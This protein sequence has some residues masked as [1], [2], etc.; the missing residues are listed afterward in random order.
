M[1]IPEIFFVCFVNSIG[2]KC[3]ETVFLLAY[4][5]ISFA[6]KFLLFHFPKSQHSTCVS[7]LFPKLLQCL[8][9]SFQAWVLPPGI[10][11]MLPRRVQSH[12]PIHWS[13][14]QDSNRACLLSWRSKSHTWKKTLCPTFW[15]VGVFICVCVC[16]VKTQN[17]V[18]PIAVEEGL[19]M[20]KRVSFRWDCITIL[21][22]GR[23]P[24]TF[25]NIII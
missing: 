5:L 17:V 16:V 13:M 18:L 15:C 24:L 11:R 10:M 23:S 19:H 6:R 21:Y 3:F 25:E 1:I 2:F 4:H 22:Q 12:K 7:C 9:T 8:R 20:Y 14:G